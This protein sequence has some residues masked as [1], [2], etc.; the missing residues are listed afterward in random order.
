MSATLNPPPQS[1]LN[2]EDKRKRKFYLFA[3]GG[4]LTLLFFVSY[5]FASYLRQPE[6]LPEL[7][8]V[9]VE[10]DYPPHY[11]FSIYEV[12]GPVGVALS[13]EGDR[14]YVTE[15]RGERLIKMFDID[16]NLLGSFSTPGAGPGERAPV[17][18]ATDS[19]G[20]VYV[21]DRLQHAIV[22]FDRDG[23]YL[24]SIL[25][26]TLTLS[27]Y[28]FKH[29]EAEPTPGSFSY[30]VFE[31]EVYYED[32]AGEQQTLP[33][34]DRSPWAPLGVRFDSNDRMLLT[35][36]IET[37]HSVWLAPSSVIRASDWLDFDL[38]ALQFGISGQ[39][40]GQLQFPNT[41]VVDS[42]GRIIISDG[43]NGRLSVWNDQGGFLF[44]FGSGSG[45]GALSLPRGI[46]IDD[47]DRLHVVDAVGQNVKVYDFSGPEPS[48]LYTFGDMGVQNGQ[49]N[50]PNDIALDA[51]GRL[52]IADREN[53]RI[54][55]WSY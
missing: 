27:E 52:Y 49:F 16:G 15:I 40:N 11:L 4:L 34:P 51:S 33:R 46:A 55:V 9:N 26:P 17:Y 24:D 32:A 38:S 14:L 7:L 13:P 45:D 1:D 22:V 28:V 12:E 37:R 50:Y 44:H 8:P 47:R 10:V 42:Q 6:P 39:G 21:T 48:F 53:N 25:N 3:L 29:T 2:A 36:V 31:T 23:N 35:D 41:A 54:Q 18:I 19:L 5:M 43:N 20:R 30:N